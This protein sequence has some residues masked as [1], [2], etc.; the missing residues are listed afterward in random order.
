MLSSAC[1]RMR[2]SFFSG[3]EKTSLAV[4]ALGYV[5]VDGPAGDRR[6]CVPNCVLTAVNP[7]LFC[8]YRLG[9]KDRDGRPHGPARGEAS[10]AGQPEASSREP[11]ID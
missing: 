6:A 11:V 7:L 1:L 3:T 5:E 10:I 8:L 4:Q 9:R 2:V